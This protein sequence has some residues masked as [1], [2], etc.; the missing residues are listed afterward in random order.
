MIIKSSTALRN[1]YNEISRLAHEKKDPIY[2][3]KNGEGDIVVMSVEGFERRDEIIRLRE[4]LAIA[5]KQQ[6]SGEATV[7]PDEAE[8]RLRVKLN[9]AIQG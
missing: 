1:D 4:R 6:L 7:S 8:R 9:E 3:T 2:I 5:E